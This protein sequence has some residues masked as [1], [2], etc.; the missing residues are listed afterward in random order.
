M[1]AG[2][3]DVVIG[4]GGNFETLAQ[5]CPAAPSMLAVSADEPEPRDARRMPLSAH[6]TVDVA[7]VRALLPKLAAMTPDERRTT[8]GMRPDRADVIVAAATIVLEIA[9]A[10]RIERIVAPGVGLREGVL[11]ELVEKHFDVWDYGGEATAAVESSLRLGRR[12]HF[13][14]AHGLLVARIAID[15]FDQLRP[16]HRLVERDRLLLQVGALLHDVGDFIRYEGHHRHSQYIIQNSDLVGIS[17]RERGIVAA[18]ARYHRK[19][20]PDPSHPGFRE[21]DRDDRSR[22]R[23]LSSI[24]RLADALDRE[25]LG[26]VVAVR[27]VPE[28][29]K[30]RLHLTGAVDRQLEEWT[31]VRKAAM[32]EEVFDLKVEIARG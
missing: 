9:D 24:L 18:L 26:K 10:L 17:P 15:L 8:F 28:K 23:V 19:S 29:G 27:V 3:F 31:V 11:D 1:R 21:L 5:L 7:A 22:V 2:A 12:Y 20:P 32:F 14:E 16:Q 6:A 30:L 4:T 25:H 13:D